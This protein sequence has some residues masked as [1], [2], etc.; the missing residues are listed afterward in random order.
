MA[1]LA[2]YRRGTLA[3]VGYARVSTVG[4]S[5]EIQLD[6]L[7]D[8]DKIFQEKESGTKE[9]RAELRACLDY[10]RE[11][12]ILTVTRLDRLA[13]STFH[14][15]SI[16]RGL[17]EKQVNLRVID[18]NIDTSDATGRL[19]FNMLASIAE[20]ETSLRS[21]RQ[22]DGIEKAKANGV[23]FGRRAKLDLIEVQQLQ[24]RRSEGVLIRTLMK[25]YGLSKASVYRYLNAGAE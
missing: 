3:N 25:E 16:A 12:D 24:R 11:G 7:S 23:Q 18:Q 17:E 15:C 20:F 1:I 4:Q 10:V 14:L 19:L 6:K 22:R 9:E 5:L 21:E 13:R 2:D 8:C